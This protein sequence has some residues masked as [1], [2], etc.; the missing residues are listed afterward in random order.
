MADD[1]SAMSGVEGARVRISSPN[2]AVE[3]GQREQENAGGDRA[4]GTR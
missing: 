1:Y 3:K 2:D 4:A